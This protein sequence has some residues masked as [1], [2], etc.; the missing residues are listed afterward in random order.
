M[1][2]NN[3]DDHLT[4]DDA[5]EPKDDD[6]NVGHREEVLEEDNSSPAAPPDD[7][8]ETLPADHPLSDSKPDEHEVYDEGLTNA[9]IPEKTAENY[10][11]NDVSP[12]ESDDDNG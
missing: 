1:Q 6:L 12:L 11:Q 9:V 10:K 7:V 8:I 4:P 2:D 3:N 5:L